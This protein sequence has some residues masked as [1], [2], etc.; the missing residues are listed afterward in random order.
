MAGK[1]LIN[2]N[3]L[4]IISIKNLEKFKNDNTLENIE[5]MCM[6]CLRIASVLQSY[7]YNEPLQQVFN[8][9]K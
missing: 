4:L 7:L 5:Q 2:L 6:Q 1:K 3:I 9:D 8:F